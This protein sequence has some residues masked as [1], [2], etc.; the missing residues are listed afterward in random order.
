MHV[1]TAHIVCL[2]SRSVV[3]ESSLN[4]PPPLAK[5]P[6]PSAAR[7]NVNSS[8]PSLSEQY[9]AKPS[10]LAVA[11]LPAQPTAA[12]KACETPAAAAAT[13]EGPKANPKRPDSELG[14]LNDRF[15][16]NCR[17]PTDEEVGRLNSRVIVMEE[18]KM[19]TLFCGT[20]ECYS[21]DNLKIRNHAY[22]NGSDLEA[23][24]TSRCVTQTYPQNLDVFTNDVSVVRGGSD[25][26]NSLFGGLRIRPATLIKLVLEHGEMNNKRDGAFAEELLQQRRRV[27]MGCCGQGYTKELVEGVTVPNATYGL[28]FFDKIKDVR[29]R[30]SAKAMIAD[31]IDA[32]QGFA[33]YTEEKLRNPMP[34]NDSQ[35]LERFAK[36]FAKSVGAEKS[37]FEDVSLQVKNLTQHERTSGHKD[38]RNCNRVGYT[39]T[40]GISFCIV[41]SKGDLWSLKIICNSRAAAGSYES[42]V[43]K[44]TPMLTRIHLQMETL[45]RAHE[46]LMDAQRKAGGHQY[47][48]KVGPRNIYDLVLEDE[49]PWVVADF[50]GGVT[51]KQ[52]KL[53]AAPVRDLHLSAATTVAFRL[54]EQLKDVRL[55]IEMVVLMAYHNGY[56]RLQHIAREHF[57]ELIDPTTSPAFAYYKRATALFDGVAFGSTQI[58][59]WQPSPVKFDEVYLNE[60]GENNGAMAVVVDGILTLLDGIKSILG[61]KEFHHVK[62]EALVRA[63]I[64]GWHDKGFKN[65]EIGEFRIMIILQI[66]CHAKVGITGHKDLLSLV[67]PV[68]KL[69]AAEQLNHVNAGDR[70]YVLRLIL[71]ETGLEAYGTNGAEGSLCETSLNRVCKI[72][73]VVYPHQMQFRIGA[74]GRNWFKKYG[75]DVWVWF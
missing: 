12:A 39:K 8:V 71:K 60:K 74:D 44:L 24:Q 6:R 54:H 41:D 7:A 16:D 29:D 14:D 69:G 1:P 19:H 10:T 17:I 33:D 20:T 43:Y 38:E 32:M 15:P 50:G 73:D 67:Y 65:F 4:I 18:D 47:H 59:R 49:C 64:K 27:P 30:L 2:P 58:G 40:V 13:S 42:N 25:L 57:D 68:S 11:E 72:Y 51:G 31:I 37:R 28:D 53:P 48:I 61:T 9:S 52:M 63:C 3:E 21:I 75:S 45:E 5:R 56:E 23:P 36:Q 34:Y 55:V 62:V 22:E 46:D 26:Y 70:P 66:C 35:R